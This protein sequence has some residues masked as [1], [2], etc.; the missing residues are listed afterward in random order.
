ML[1]SGDT[2]QV[3]TRIPVPV[4]Y[5][6]SGWVEQSRGQGI[7][8]AG[9]ENFKVQRTWASWLLDDFGQPRCLSVSN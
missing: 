6:N 1:R 3:Q 7:Q 4:R 8:L 5:V 2:H 9:G